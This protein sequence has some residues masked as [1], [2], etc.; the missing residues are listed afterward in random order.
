MSIFTLA[1]KDLSLLLRDTRSAVILFLMPV[2]MVVLLGIVVG[3]AFERDRL[4]VSVVILDAG[5][6]LEAGSFPG[7]PWSEIVL[8]DLE[9]T[10]E[11]RIERLPSIE[12]A[13][14]LVNRSKR[15]AVLIF[16]AKFSAEMQR[17]SFLTKANPEPLNP[18]YRDGI[19]IEKLGLKL[20]RDPTQPVAAS[21]I[22]QVAQVSLI[23]VVI[24]WMIGKA[25]DRV[26]DDEFMEMM[27]K[28]IPFYS[29][30]PGSVKKEMG[31]AVKKGIAILFSKYDFNA[32][33]WKGLTKDRSGKTQEKEHV[34]T[35]GA[36]FLNRG[37]LR[38]QILVPS[39]TVM[40]AFFL[41]LT[42]GWLFVGERRQGT[43][44]RLRAAPLS[45][46]EL[47]LGK[48]IPCLVIS[49]FQ[50]FFLLLAGKLVFGMSWGPQPLWLIPVVLSTSFAAMGLALIVAGLSKTESQVAV[51]GTLLVLVLAVISGSLMPRDLMPDE[52]K[53]LSYITPH[54]WAL[55]AYAQLLVNPAPVF[56]EVGKACL[57]LIGFGTGF[58]G[59]A[60][61]VV[62]LE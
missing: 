41:I 31:P 50:G 25:F 30:V 13:Q 20:L 51:F 12:E 58:L 54:A 61:W 38:Y 46:S 32:K 44:T 3:E 28:Q 35:K 48:L 53:Q 18:L 29:L 47:L 36:G 52:L 33:T 40:F 8:E 10:A 43:L 34:V 42:M 2:L 60:W 5:L 24:P 57:I 21:V 6:G 17:S 19:D 59:V 45:R 27:G 49:W 4:R 1:K 22:E 23:R 26:G 9:Q 56:S 11:I 16:E 39:Y 14:D 15:P 62:R 7:R 55:D 37:A